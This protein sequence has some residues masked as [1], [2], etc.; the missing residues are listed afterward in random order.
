[1]SARALP[2]PFVAN[3]ITKPE[4]RIRDFFSE[5]PIGATCVISERRIQSPRRPPD[6]RAVY[7]QVIRRLRAFGS[8]L[9][10]LF[11]IYLDSFFQFYVYF[12]L[13]FGV[14]EVSYRLGDC[15]KL[16]RVFA[17]CVGE[18]LFGRV[19]GSYAVA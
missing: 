19:P 3:S 8:C 12:S 9:L 10:P 5:K 16:L 2:R 14:I 1:L 6:V 4:G 17:Y 18:K 13:R 11:P 15:K 7:R